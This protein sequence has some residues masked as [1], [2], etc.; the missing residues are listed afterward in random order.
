MQGSRSYQPAADVVGQV[1]LI[2]VLLVIV[3]F[4]VIKLRIAIGIGIHS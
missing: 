1:E 3:G 4:I 2:V